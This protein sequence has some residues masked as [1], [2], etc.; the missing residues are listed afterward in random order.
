MALDDIL[1]A[2]RSHADTD[3]AT[4]RTDHERRMTDL[5]TAARQSMERQ[6]R[7]M[8]EQKERKLKQLR[9][10]AEAYAATHLRHTT[11]RTKQRQLDD[12]YRETVSTLAAAPAATAEPLLRACLESVPRNGT[13]K[14]SKHHAALIKKLAGQGH[15]IGESID[16]AGGFVFISSDREI[17]CTFETLVER[18]LRPQTELDVSSSLFDA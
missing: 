13:I 7:E 18:V 2:I 1:N 15:E 6:E 17:D 5:R 9:Q 10:K 11:L 12:V 16:A 3:R 4:A 8:D 14:P